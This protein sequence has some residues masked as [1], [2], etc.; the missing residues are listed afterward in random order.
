MGVNLIHSAFYKAD[1]PHSIIRYLYDHI[2]KDLIEIDMINFSGPK[3]GTVDNR[4]MS[5]QLIKNGMTEAVMFDAQGNNLLPAEELYKKN[6]LTIRGSFR[7]VANVNIDML[8]RSLEL[9][10]KEKGVEKDNTEV[11]FEITL[12]NLLASGELDE[13]DF[14]DRARILSSL[15][16]KV[17]IS[18]FKEYYRLAEYFSNYTKAQMGMVMG[19]D[20]LIAIFK[21]EYYTHL[22]GGILEAFGKL[23]YR[24]IKIYLYPMRDK[25]TGQIITSNNIQ[26]PPRMKELYKFFKFNEKVVD[27]HNYDAKNL[28]I[29]SRDI[30]QKIKNG[31][32]GWQSS[33]PQGVAEM[34]ETYGY[35][36]WKKK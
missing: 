6:I 13:Q 20:N 32:D 30:V 24:D 26:V 25:D 3:F 33:L 18:N 19:A 10:L 15:G 2:D 29:R 8:E 21:E 4:L 14:M 17:L 23:F 31:E 16:Y 9:F 36:G 7:P 12:S 11:I 1:K 34:I 5:L 22:S 27:I 28:E 35:F